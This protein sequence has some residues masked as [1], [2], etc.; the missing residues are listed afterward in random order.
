[1][2][3]ASSY[4]P[5]ILVLE[6]ERSTRDLLDQL[7]SGEGYY[8][9]AV[10]TAELALQALRKLN[11][12]LAILDFSLLNRE[13]LTVLK[14]IQSEF[15][16]TKTLVMAS[17]DMVVPVE[18]IGATATLATPES[19]ETLMNAVYRLLDPSGSWADGPPTKGS[20]S[21][22][23]MRMHKVVDD[24][25]KGFRNHPDPRVAKLA[26]ALVRCPGCLQRCP[27][28]EECNQFL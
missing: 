21:A 15:P 5:R 14:H 18:A 11:F 24:Y 19:P 27:G 12:R 2:E 20:R 17:A 13:G 22:A 1:M 16:S 8:V 6:K 10:A 9:A 4:A 28:I 23:D 26:A 7:L 25:L 3:T